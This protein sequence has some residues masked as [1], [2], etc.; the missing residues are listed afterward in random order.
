MAENLNS[1]KVLEL[2]D[3][4]IRIRYSMDA[5]HLHR[6]FTVI[7]MTDYMILTRLGRTMGINKPETRV[8]LSEISKEMNRPI[9]Q[10]S[11]MVQN[12][13]AK[14]YVYWEHDPEQRS[15]TYIYISETGREAMTRQQ[16]ILHRYF[17][18]IVNRLGEENVAEILD[19][20]YRLETV[21]EEEAERLSEEMTVTAA[22]E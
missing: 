1:G 16:E 22:D 18:N 14:G 7:S 4:I 10:V 5:D 17:E 9:N 6:V 13:Q 19:M 3:R 12:L 21:M 11:Q 20:M 2:G 15:G 8:Y